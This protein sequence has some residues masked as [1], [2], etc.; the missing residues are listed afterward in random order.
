LTNR[1]CPNTNNPGWN[2]FLPA[3]GAIWMSGG[4]P[5][6]DAG[7]IYVTT[8]NGFFDVANRNYGDTAIKLSP[9]ISGQ[10]DVVDYFTPASQLYLM[11]HD[12][13]FGAGS[14]VLLPDTNPALLVLISKRGDLYLLSRTTGEM[15]HYNDNCPS[16]AVSCDQVVQVIGFALEGPV[17][18][19]PAYFNGAVFAQGSN[20]TLMKFTLQNGQFSPITPAAQTVR[21]FTYPATPSISYDASA[22][23]PVSSGI[24]WTLERLKGNNSILHA[25]TTDSLR[26]LYRSDTQ[27]TRDTLGITGTFTVPIIAAGKVFVGTTNEL[28]VYG[29][30]F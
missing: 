12:D 3:G 11:C 17:T 14:P 9:Q 15:G 16:H 27:G 30:R 22:A 2:G 25:Y 23:N 1:I 6:A 13:D 18:S 28:V 7:G 24:V 29:G 26:E 4:G 5:A 10:L 20:N 8:G 19:S 21:R